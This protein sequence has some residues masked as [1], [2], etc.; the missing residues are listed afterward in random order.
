MPGPFLTQTCVGVDAGV[1]V[2]VLVGVK[3]GSGVL[4]GG[5]GVSLGIGVGIGVACGV[6]L[7][8]KRTNMNKRNFILCITLDLIPRSCAVHP[9]L[10]TGQ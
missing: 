1:A 5:C 8:T 6:Q 4:V 2:I 7:A 9:K 10:A 3:L